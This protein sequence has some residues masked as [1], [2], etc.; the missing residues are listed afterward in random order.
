MG[1]KFFKG[2]DDGDIDVGVYDD[3][4]LRLSTLSLPNQTDELRNL[5][6]CIQFDDEEPSVF[7]S[8]TGDLTLS[9]P[10]GG[11]ISFRQGD[12]TFKIFTR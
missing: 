3:S 8:G 10:L 5:E 6:Y 7:G 12:K 4:L 2:E 11:D 9:I 1:F